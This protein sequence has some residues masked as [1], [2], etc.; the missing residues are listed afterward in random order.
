M[1]TFRASPRR[2]VSDQFRALAALGQELTDVHLLESSALDDSDVAFPVVGDDVVEPK[3]PRVLRGRVSGRRCAGD[4][5]VASEGRVYINGGARHARAQYFEGIDPDVWEFRIGGY[6]PLRKWLQDRKGRQLSYDDQIHY[7]HIA[8]A[9]RETI[10]LM[11][12]IDEA[13][14]PFP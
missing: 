13:G 2:T 1:S 8:A 10:R 6:Q 9:L 14:L 4:H 3:H 5:A 12:A 11:A 7:I